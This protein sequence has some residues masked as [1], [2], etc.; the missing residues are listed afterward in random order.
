MHPL[1]DDFDRV[2]VQ[3]DKWER[4]SQYPDGHFVRGIGPIGDVEVGSFA[5]CHLCMPIDECVV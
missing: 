3:I 1:L 2:V 4:G 5:M